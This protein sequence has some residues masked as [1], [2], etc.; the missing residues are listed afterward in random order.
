MDQTN[1]SPNQRVTNRSRSSL[2]RQR[3]ATIAITTTVATA[4]A[5]KPS[6]IRPVSGQLTTRRSTMPNRTGIAVS[7]ASRWPPR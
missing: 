5:T 4:A 7:A 6:M 2:A 1:P 3:Q